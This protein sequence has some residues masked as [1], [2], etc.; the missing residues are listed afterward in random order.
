MAFKFNTKLFTSLL[1]CIKLGIMYFVLN[2]QI[3]NYLYLNDPII[4]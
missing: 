4:I 2:F 1:D 3:F